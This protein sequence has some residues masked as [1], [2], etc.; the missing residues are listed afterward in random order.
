MPKIPKP[1][2]QNLNK[3]TIDLTKIGFGGVNVY[4]FM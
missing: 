2:I 4:F 3:I 1:S